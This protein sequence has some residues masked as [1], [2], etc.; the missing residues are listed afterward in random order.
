MKTNKT[1]IS[2]DDHSAIHYKLNDVLRDGKRKEIGRVID[3]LLELRPVQQHK[4]PKKKG[5]PK[6]LP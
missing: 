3:L 1:A 2:P 4:A 5:Q 6:R